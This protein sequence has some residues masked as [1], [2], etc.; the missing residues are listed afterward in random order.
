MG[1]LLRW[2]RAFFRLPLRLEGVFPEFPEEVRRPAI[3]SLWFW[4]ALAASYVIWAGDLADVGRGLGLVPGTLAAVVLAAVWLVLP[5]DPR[6]SRRRKLAAPAFLVAVFAMDLFFGGANW[7]LA[8]YPLAFANG[9]FLF[10]F[11]RGIAY[12]AATLVV[13][14]TET[15]LSIRL[16]YPEYA[17]ESG[18]W[19]FV[20]ALDMAALFVPVAAFFIGVCV[21]IVEANRRREE[22]QALLG[23]L[24]AT[25]AE[26]ES[27]YAQLKNYAETVRE[28]AVSE[29]R[30]RMAREMHDSVG[31]Y[32]TVVNVQ[33][34]AATKLMD[35]NPARAREEVAKAKALASEALAEVRRSVRALKPPAVERRSVVVALSAVARHFEG[36]GLIVSFKVGG[37]ERSLPTEV[38]LALYRA[39]QESM[40]NALKH[41]K[42][43]R[44][45]VSLTFGEESVRLTVTDD[46]V[47]A[48]VDAYERGFG[49][50]ALRERAEALGGS[51]KA[52]NGFEGGF[53][54]EIELPTGPS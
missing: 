7:S 49:L 48:P 51:L 19:A 16:D 26:L 4:S 53:A 23:E 1:R 28:L 6:A 50:T 44:I 45:F 33:L 14:F 20:N 5:W 38:E 30:A 21:P 42:A 37:E 8:F 41:S 47:G 34:E 46:G 3:F 22:T 13:I 29:E 27:A 54:L 43:R 11:R 24:E 32:L 10:G 35:G 12:A 9:V 2:G 31:H 36:A 52:G 39:L 15:L 25:H 40:T 17:M 18:G